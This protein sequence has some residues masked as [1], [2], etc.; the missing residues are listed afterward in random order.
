MKFVSDDIAGTESWDASFRLHGL[1]VVLMS[2]VVRIAR[3]DG[4]LSSP[5]HDALTSTLQHLD[6][7]VAEHMP[8]GVSAAAYHL[9]PLD[10]QE[11]LLA[12]CHRA[13]GLGCLQHPE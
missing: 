5:G 3:D 10:V 11:V 7:L 9:M 2:D 13:A 12:R 6:E 4:S 8:N 1:Y